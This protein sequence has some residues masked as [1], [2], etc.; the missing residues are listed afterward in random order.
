MQSMGRGK[1]KLNLQN[2]LKS[3]NHSEEH[4]LFTRLNS[5]EIMIDG[6]EQCNRWW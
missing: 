6:S 1:H 3:T 5:I 2:G 4:D